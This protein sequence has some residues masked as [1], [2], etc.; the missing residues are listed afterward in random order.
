[1]RKSLWYSMLDAD[2][3]ARYWSYLSRRYSNRD[4]Y[5]KI[6]LALMSSGT[7]ASW[8]FW[9]DMQIIWK[10]LSACSA[11]LAIALPIINWPKMISNMGVL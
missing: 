5:S 6:F 2:M 10:I 4:K 7:V 9:S 1:M 11:L 8:G 3:N